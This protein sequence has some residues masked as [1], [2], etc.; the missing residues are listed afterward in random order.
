MRNA[1]PAVMGTHWNQRWGRACKESG[2][3]A[4]HCSTTGDIMGAKRF[5]CRLSPGQAELSMDDELTEITEYIQGAGWPEANDFWSWCGWSAGDRLRVTVIATGFQT[6]KKRWQRKNKNRKKKRDK[7]KVHDLD[8]VNL[9]VRAGEHQS[10]NEIQLKKT[11][12]PVKRLRNRKRR[13]NPTAVLFRYAG[14][15]NRLKIPKTISA[16]KT[17]LAIMTMSS[18]AKPRS[19][20]IRSS[21]KSGWTRPFG[22]TAFAEQAKERKEKLEECAQAGDDKKKSSTK[23]G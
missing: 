7:K 8:R 17:S 10:R 14:E 16:M 18:S 22:K 20:E 4:H 12:E 23:S 21:T 3:W 6:G 19:M 11:E 13:Q 9:D 1:G 5:C 2:H 15:Q